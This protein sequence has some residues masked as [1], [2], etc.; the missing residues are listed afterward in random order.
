MASYGADAC[1][2]HCGHTGSPWF[3]LT[4]GLYVRFV[5]EVI[6]L[7]SHWIIILSYS[8]KLKIRSYEYV[9]V[10]IMHFFMFCSVSLLLSPKP[11]QLNSEVVGIYFS[12]YVNLHLVKYVWRNS[13]FAEV[14]RI[15]SYRC[16]GVLLKGMFSKFVFCS[17]YFKDMTKAVF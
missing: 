9:F 4:W 13:H 17:R 15:I 2:A 3:G 10:T 16:R 8:V 1:D 11:T 6:E 14:C 12:V 5:Y 7:T